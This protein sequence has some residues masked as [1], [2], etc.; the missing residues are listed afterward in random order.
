MV[1]S[2]L[3]RAGSEIGFEDVGWRE[4]HRRAIVPKRDV[5]LV[6][7]EAHGVFGARD[8]FPQVSVSISLRST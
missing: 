3:W 5:A 7:L 8:V 4:V 2:T 6:P 1:P